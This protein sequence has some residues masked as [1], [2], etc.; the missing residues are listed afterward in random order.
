MDKLPGFDLSTPEYIFLNIAALVLSSKRDNYQ[1]HRI[2][3]LRSAARKISMNLTGEYFNS[4]EIYPSEKIET[5]VKLTFDVDK[6][7]LDGKVKK[8]VGEAVRSV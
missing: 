7:D 3:R 8:V 1:M 2:A 6:A 5:K 4:E